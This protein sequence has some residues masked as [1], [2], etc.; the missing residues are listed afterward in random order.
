MPLG[1]SITYGYGDATFAG[2]RG[3]LGT[4]LA[5]RAAAVD[6]VGS[7]QAGPATIDR[8]NEGHGGFRTDE[9]VAQVSTYLTTNPAYLVLL[10]AGTNDIAQSFASTENRIGD[11][12]DAVS[13][14][15]PGITIFVSTLPPFFDAGFQTERNRVNAALP[16]VVTAKQ[17]SGINVTLVDAGN[18]VLATDIVPLGDP[19]EGH[20]NTTGYAKMAAAWNAALLAAGH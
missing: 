13:A 8:D 14:A 7:L 12:I 3:P 11:L 17:G 9:L 6:F 4:L 18:L 16:A 1:D 2:Y 10:M 19:L 5:A 15:S 20:P